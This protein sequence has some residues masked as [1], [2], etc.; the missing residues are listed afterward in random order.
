[1][2]RTLDPLEIKRDRYENR[3]VIYA[4]DPGVTTGLSVITFDKPCSPVDVLQWG[5][6]QISYGGSGNAKD[7]VEGDSAWK[8]QEICHE[9]AKN[10]SEASLSAKSVSV[11]IEDFIIRRVDSSRDFLSPV[12][13]TA[14]IM[15]GIYD[16][17]RDNVFVF[18]QQ[19][20]QAKGTCTDARLDKW[21]FKISTQKDRHSRDADRHALLLLRRFVEN[22][23]L[24]QSP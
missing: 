24:L 12:R 18:F 13:I 14:G 10:I 7:F 1:M 16:S 4:I 6:N 19:P 2:E 5:S 20:S 17:D 8:E 11:V 3:H 21:G 23:R 22:P 9:I 15:Q